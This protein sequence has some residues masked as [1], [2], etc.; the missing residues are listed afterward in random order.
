VNP[1]PTDRYLN[2]WVCQLTGGLLGYAQFP[3][4]P[5]ATDGVVIL[6]TAFGT[7]GVTQAPFNKGWPDPGCWS[8][9]CESRWVV[10]VRTVGGLA[11]GLPS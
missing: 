5:A 6:Y 3:G 10:A 9:A 11:D 1:W 8:T 7:R 2:M 4:G